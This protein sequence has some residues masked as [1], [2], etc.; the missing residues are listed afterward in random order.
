[1]RLTVEIPDNEHIYLKMC[2]AKLNEK[3]KDF[4][5]TAIIEKIEEFEDLW[6]LENMESEGE[7]DFNPK[8]Y[9]SLE[10]VYEKLGFE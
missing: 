5:G 3:I 1:M 7:L 2:C 4:C 8:N 10:K 9:T 6:T